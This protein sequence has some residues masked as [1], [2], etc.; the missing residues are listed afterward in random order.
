MVLM[1]E[2][3]LLKLIQLTEEP[4]FLVSNNH[5]IIEINQSAEKKLGLKKSH[6]IGSLLSTW[7]SNDDLQ[8]LCPS[9]LERV[10]L[11]KGKISLVCYVA[12]IEEPVQNSPDFCMEKIFINQEKYKYLEAIIGEVPVSVYW[13][14][15]DYIYLGCSNNMAQL[16]GLGSRHDIVGKTYADLYDKK[17]AAVYKKTDASVIE[18]GI[19]LSEE[20]PLYFADGTKKIYLSKKVPLHDEQRTIIG[21]LGIS[22]D[23]TE[24][25]K[26]EEE[27]HIAKEKAEAANIAK[28]EFI[29]NMSH[30]IRTPL[31]GVIGMSELL[32]HT[33]Q[34]PEDKEKAH[35]LHDSGEELLHMLNEILDD[36]RAGNLRET[37]VKDGSFDLHQCIRDLIRLERPATS[38]KGLQLK[39]DIAPDAKHIYFFISLTRST[40]LDGL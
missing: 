14:N 39:A 11:K 7:C 18:Q 38:L 36:V 37:D 31:T 15:T 10:T 25:K 8:R 21:M 12:V 9:A 32:E 22:T 19:S 34:N 26:M 1:N 5:I 40:V 27:L 6:I 29:A 23:I 28:T 16:L 30:D 35:L 13:M 33:L 20:E 4:F 24:R 2:H 17:S 3:E